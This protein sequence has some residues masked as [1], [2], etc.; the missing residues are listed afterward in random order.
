MLAARRA[1][2]D[3]RRRRH[4]QRRRR[5]P[6]GGV[7]RADRRA[8]HPDPD[9]LGRH[10]RRPP[11]D[12]RHGRPADL[13]PLRQRDH[14]G[15]RLRAR[16]R[17]P[18]GQPAHRRPGRLPRGPHVR[19]RRH[20]ADPDRPGLRARLRHRLRR[21]GGAASCSSRW[22]GSATA[23]ARCRT[24]S[25]WVEECQERKRTMQRRTHFDD[26]PIKPQRVYEE[27]NKA[28]GPDTRYVTT[29]GLSQIA[30]GAVP[31]RLPAAALDQL[32]ARPA[33]WAGRI[34]AALGRVRRRPG[35]DRRR[36]VRRLRLP[37]HDRGAGGRRAVQPALHPRRW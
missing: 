10:P 34:P 2:A 35:G 27:M 5:R 6:A 33:R 25:A 9:G 30:G 23:P 36:A 14:A 7:R 31:A 20:R 4:H 17:Q 22:R 28:F 19:P 32:P 13:A 12:G 11:A 29:I 8:G 26:I 15:V 3:R 1:A 24:A 18:L 37:V 16:H 21:Q